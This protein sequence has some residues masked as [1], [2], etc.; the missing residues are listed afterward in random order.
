[1][2]LSAE[3]ENIFLLEQL[4]EHS[5]NAFFLFDVNQQQFRYLSP[6]FEGLWERSRHE[7]ATD[8][9]GILH[10]VFPQDR[11]FVLRSWN[12]YRRPGRA[13]HKSFE[14]RLQ[15][16]DGRIKWDFAELFMVRNED[17]SV[18]LSGWAR[19][20]TKRKEYLEILRNYAAK[21]NATLEVLTHDLAGFLTLIGTLTS[22]IS[23]N[24]PQADPAE[25]AHKLNLIKET[26]RRGSELITDLVNHEFI[27]S[28]QVQ[29][30]K[31]RLDMVQKIGEIVTMYQ[32]GEK[33][34][35]K[36]F[37]L[38]S[39]MP[40][41]FAQIDDV[42]FMQV[43]NNLVSNSIKFTPVGGNIRIWLEERPDTVLIEVADNGIGIP[44]ALQPILF[45]R[46]TEARRPGL[47]G[48]PTIGLGMNIIRSIVD[49]HGG[50]IWFST[51]EGEG[52][53]FYIELPKD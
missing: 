4:A 37:L 41:I 48:E 13:N 29:L 45:N 14:F 6:A 34:L 46:F 30:N 27:E 52:T 21:K 7:I 53:T 49:L 17:N 20:V 39:N 23:N 9:K 10:T 47:K 2:N 50:R 28:A 22:N 32:A 12:W 25:V 1:M 26:C 15:F 51:R 33:E 44:D 11:N 42:K 43:I 35:G 16:P 8:F 40:Q 31:Q 36:T 18:C 24:L 5:D 3:P 19:E 38:K